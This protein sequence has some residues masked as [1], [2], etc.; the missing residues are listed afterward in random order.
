[1]EWDI[2]AGHII[3]KNSG[4]NIFSTNLKELEYGKPDFLNSSF[5]AFNHLEND[6]KNKFIL[7]L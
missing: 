3:L 1:M 2:A 4:G 7:N 6:I 5:I